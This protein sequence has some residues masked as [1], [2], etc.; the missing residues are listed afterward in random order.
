M[1]R[2]TMSTSENPYKQSTCLQ[3]GRN[4]NLKHHVYHNK[5]NLSLFD[6]Q[7]IPSGKGK[8]MKFYNTLG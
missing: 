3:I 2:F 7:V 5:N 1:Y 8:E 4:S 6:R